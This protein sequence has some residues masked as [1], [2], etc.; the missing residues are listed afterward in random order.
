MRKALTIAFCLFASVALPHS[1][2]GW[3]C[4]S[5]RDCKPVPAGDVKATAAGWKV[6]ITGEVIAFS[7]RKI[8]E[9]PDKNFHRCARSADFSA[10]GATLCLYVP[11][12]GV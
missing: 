10:K 9:S 4:C 12:A 6:V 5:G 8:K 2:Y 11:P 3:E 7:D 1:F